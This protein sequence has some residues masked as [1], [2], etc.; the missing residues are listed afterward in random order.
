MG[1]GG[2]GEKRRGLG[3]RNDV[4]ATCKAV[5]LRCGQGMI[6]VFSQNKCFR[7]ENNN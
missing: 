4:L 7:S 2:R 1:G 5:T 6:A 3:Q